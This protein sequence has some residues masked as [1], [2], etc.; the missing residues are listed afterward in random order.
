MLTRK[1]LGNDPCQIDIPKTIAKLKCCFSVKFQ[2][3]LLFV[4]PILE[5]SSAV[6]K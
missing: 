5:L 1:P 6:H 4:F 2:N 3:T